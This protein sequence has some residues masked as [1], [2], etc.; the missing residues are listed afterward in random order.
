MMEDF[1]LIFYNRH[2]VL[3][4]VMISSIQLGI[5]HISNFCFI[6]KIL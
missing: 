5:N 2:F 4:F 1:V 3:L 6:K